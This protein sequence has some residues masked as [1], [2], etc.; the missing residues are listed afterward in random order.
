MSFS[1]QEKI[2]GRRLP[3]FW[4]K[5]KKRRVMKTIK[6]KSVIFT[7]AGKTQSCAETRD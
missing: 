1:G 2:P 6:S 3:L 7:L 5:T 4:E